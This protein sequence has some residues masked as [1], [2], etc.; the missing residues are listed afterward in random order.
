MTVSLDLPLLVTVEEPRQPCMLCDG[1]AV[2]VGII[3]TPCAH[4]QP[5]CLAHYERELPKWTP[6]DP[7]ACHMCR[8]IALEDV[9]EF[10]C[11][12]DA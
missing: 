6:G 7:I 3:D 12:E 11:W 5:L 2:K 8:P 9:G 10:V 4:P 1:E